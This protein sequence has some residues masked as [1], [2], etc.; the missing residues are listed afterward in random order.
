MVLF[1]ALNNVDDNVIA[2]MLSAGQVTDEEYAGFWRMEDK[3]G[4]P[5]EQIHISGDIAKSLQGSMARFFRRLALD[6][7]VVRSNYFLQA[8]GEEGQRDGVDPEELAWGTTS[9]GPEDEFGGHAHQGDSDKRDVPVE[10]V[11][12]R[13]ERQTLRRLG[14]SGAVAFTIRTIHGAGGGAGGG[15]SP[16]ARPAQ[17]ARG[18]PEV[19]HYK[20][21][22]W[23]QVA[24]RIQQE[25]KQMQAVMGVIGWRRSLT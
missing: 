6:K 2:L 22:A 24:D 25:S 23:E 14:V 7:P 21:G 20:G 17:W 18:L 8:L 5:L 4:L 19:Q 9:N 13:T 11:L 1:R 10:R 15:G 3:I 16:A 12:M